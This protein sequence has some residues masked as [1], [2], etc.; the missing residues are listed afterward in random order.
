MNEILLWF[1]A[2]MIIASIAWYA[3]LVF[4]VGVKGGYEILQMVRNLSTRPEE[5]Q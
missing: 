3:I 4:Y 1:W 5:D 2:V